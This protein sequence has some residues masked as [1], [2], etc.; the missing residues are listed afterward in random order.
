VLSRF[1][2]NQISLLIIRF[3][4]LALAHGHGRNDPAAAH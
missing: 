2:F 1:L 4:A 3:T